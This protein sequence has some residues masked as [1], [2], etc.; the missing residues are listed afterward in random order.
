MVAKDSGLDP[1]TLASVVTDDGTVATTTELPIAM[2][3]N[4]PY[5]T[6][7]GGK[8]LATV[9][10]GKN[11]SVNCLLGVPFLK[12]VKATIDLEAGRMTS[13]SVPPPVFDGT[14]LPS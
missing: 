13:T 10:V 6:L 14:A 2:T 3:F 7:E 1:L 4:T 9:A 5:K 12:S 11:V 8:V